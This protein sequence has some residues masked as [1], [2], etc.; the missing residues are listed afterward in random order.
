[1]DLWSVPLQHGFGNMLI[2]PL[3]KLLESTTHV[4]TSA[5]TEELL[6]NVAMMRSR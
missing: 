2:D 3:L 4:P 6:Y 1:M 5:V